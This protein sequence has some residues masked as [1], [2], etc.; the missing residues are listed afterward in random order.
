[1]LIDAKIGFASAVRHPPSLGGC[2]LANSVHTGERAFKTPSHKVVILHSWVESG[3]RARIETPLVLRARPGRVLQADRR[4]LL[5]DR[6]MQIAAARR[7]ND[8]TLMIDQ[9]AAQKRTLDAAG[10]HLP[11]ERRI[12]L[13]GFR[14]GGANSEALI[15]I[16]QNDI[17]IVAGG[18]V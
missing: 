4:G 8:V 5:L 9:G 16:E 1:R 7:A 3:L 14:L 12:A 2:G 10:E 18:D 15:R 13:L 11:L 6:P 17:G